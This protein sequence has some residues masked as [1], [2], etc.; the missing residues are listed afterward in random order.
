[1]VSMHT[2]NARLLIFLVIVA[3]IAILAGAFAYL[4]DSSKPD[5]PI[6]DFSYSMNDQL[7]DALADDGVMVS[8]P[9]RL[10]KASAIQKYC[11]FFD[12]P[13]KQSQIEYCT[14]TELSNEQGHFLGN[15]HM[16]GTPENPR[17]VM[18]VLEA[19]LDDVDE[20][21]AIFD[22]VIDNTVCEC[23]EAESPGGLSSVHAWVVALGDFHQQATHQTT[24]KSSVLTLNGLNLQIE[25]TA[26]EGAHVWK[27]FIAG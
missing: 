26:I 17:L 1:M 14:S 8:S 16:V 25:A 3:G 10:S 6:L 12:D 18:V 21:A 13:V 2:M 5:F 7:K 4:S 23:W 27:L 15:V 9:L 20:V 19:S 22:V 11:T 24:T